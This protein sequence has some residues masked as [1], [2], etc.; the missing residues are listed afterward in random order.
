MQKH[1]PNIKVCLV[2]YIQVMIPVIQ[3]DA[4]DESL[5]Y[6]IPTENSF[7]LCFTPQAASKLPY[8]QVGSRQLRLSDGFGKGMPIVGVVGC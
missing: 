4:G 2:G 3:V 7:V 8:Q 5:F 6:A 1:K